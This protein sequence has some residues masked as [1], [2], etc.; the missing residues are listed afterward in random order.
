MWLARRIVDAMSEPILGHASRRLL[1]LKLCGA[2]ASCGAAFLAGGCGAGGVSGQ[3]QFNDLTTG[4]LTGMVVFRGG[5][6]HT[7]RHAIPESGVVRVL[8][9]TGKLVGRQR[10]RPGQ[11]FVF[12][13]TAG[14]YKL[15]A[16]LGGLGCPPVVVTVHGG[17]T[18]NVDLETHCRAPQRAG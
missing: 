15:N 16:E 7:P 6:Y 14:V 5:A 9:E 3:P 2:L 18:T 13:L 1:L 10:V 17:G 11:Q 4:T 12:R 8:M